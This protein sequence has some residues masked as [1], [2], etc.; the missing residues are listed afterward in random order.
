MTLI[1]ML[2]ALII[3]RLA[4]R[5]NAWQAQRYVRAYL[6]F[7]LN[8]PLAALARHQLGQY[9]W[10]VLPG[11]V[12]TLVLCLFDSRLLTLIVNTL[13]LLVGI[14]CWHYRQLYKQYLNA[15]ERGDAESAHLTMQQ[16]R[17]DSGSSMEQNSYGQTLI[18][19]NFRYYAATAFWFLVFGAFGVITYALL[20]QLQE[21]VTLSTAEETAGSNEEV[22][23][24]AELQPDTAGPDAVQYMTFWAQWLPTRLFGLGF[25]LVGYFSRASNTLLAYF[26]D[27][28]TDNEQVLTEVAVA[29]EPL[30]QEQLN[31]ADETSAMV[32]LAKRN[33]LF[34]LALVAVLTLSGVLR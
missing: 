25:A 31:T 32:Q 5:S 18:W 33:M 23:A 19:L 24:Y 34:F 17:N 7:S 1:S 16:I 22:S 12:V 28:S 11:A 21:P 15:Q 9:V 27:F 26:M 3:E 30:E 29:A 8:T 6:K 10:I 4:V 14:G 2:L 13:V 20:R